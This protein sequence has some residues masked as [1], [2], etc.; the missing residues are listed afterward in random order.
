[1]NRFG[2]TLALAVLTLLVVTLS[3]V[4]AAGPHPMDPLSPDEIITAATI[5][6]GGGAAQPGAIFQAIDLR[7]PAK[8]AVLG[9]HPG[10]PV[11]RRATVFFRQNKKSFRSVV[12][13]TSGSFTAPVEIPAHRWPARPHVPGDHR[14]RLRRSRTPA[15][16]GR[17]PG[18]AST[19][20]RSWPTCW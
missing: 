11:A 9:F 6:L 17:W 2:T 12:N 16:C 10:D 13:L 20:P 5:L 7:E 18:A 14:L 19:P 15:S 4:E 3:A 1:M 8:D